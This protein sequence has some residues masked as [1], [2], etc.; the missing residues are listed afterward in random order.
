MKYDIII[1]GSGLGGLIAGAK[2]SK[3][4]KKVFLI[5]QHSK[6]GGCATTFKR[7]DFVF[8]VG[9]HEMDYP[10]PSEMKSRI[11][12]DLDVFKNVEFIKVPEFYHFDN[13]RVRV[14]IPHDPEAA[15]KK[16]ILIFPDESSG[17]NEWFRLLVTPRKKNKPE[18]Q[19]PDK[20]VGEYLDSIISNDDLK[21]ILMGNL[22]YFHDDPYALSLSYY[23]VAQ[24]SY[25]LNGA[26]FVK[27]GSQKLST[28][29]SEYIK[30]HGG[31]VLLGNLVTELSISDG[32]VTGIS[33]RKKKI[34][35][36]EVLTANAD[37]FICNGSIPGLKNIL[38]EKYWG[39]LEH[40]I[41]GE[42]TGPSLLT[43]FLGFKRPPLEIG[44]KY[45]SAFIYDESIKT[46]SDIKNNNREDYSKRSFTF[47]DYT[48]IDSGL[49]PSG[50]GEGVICCMD[51]LEDWDKLDEIAYKSK[52]ERVAEILTD[53]LEKYIPGIK[54]EIEYS[55]VG[56][57]R[58]VKRY[59]LNTG[60]ATHGF[61]NT[62]SRKPPEVLKS[63][64][65]LH[66]ASAWGKTGGGF[67]GAIYGGYLTALSLL[68][69]S[70]GN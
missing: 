61:V 32:C 49:A 12:T 52:K 22:G 18:D 38:T 11:F 26:C 66:F 35:D 21:L 41:A 43:I 33:Y 65:N 39:E 44:N 20:S 64:Q 8:E 4:G 47:V 40:D 48:Q 23:A 29:L 10:A 67:S 62:P 36:S 14:T 54:D 70:R 27:G 45:Y 24:G 56:T 69:K 17:I 31:E 68:R 5:E 9:L 30:S 15:A 1:I 42:I 59:T 57:P 51:Y 37:H 7:G 28:Y 19:E 34:P 58:T 3:E 60:G 16:L 2:L 6:P 25:F 53:R 55:E 46:L 13:N 50:K 63:L